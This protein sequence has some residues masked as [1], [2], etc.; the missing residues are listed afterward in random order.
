MGCLF[1]KK[2]EDVTTAVVLPY[3]YPLPIYAQEEYGYQLT[4]HQVKAIKEW[5]PSTT[6]HSGVI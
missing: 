6:H 2:S 1:S 4:T 3:S 5:I